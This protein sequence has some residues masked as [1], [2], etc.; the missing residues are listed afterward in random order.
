MAET[1]PI[2]GGNSDALAIPKLRGKAN[3][4]TIKPETASTDQ[5]SFKPSIPSFGR[6]NFDTLIRYFFKNFDKQIGD[7]SR[8]IPEQ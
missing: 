4:K 8:Q 5:F 2:I 7:N 3:K 6:I 1:K